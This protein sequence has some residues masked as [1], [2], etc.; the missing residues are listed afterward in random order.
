MKAADILMWGSVNGLK[1]GYLYNWYSA[2]D[3][4]FA[5]TNWSVPT[6][7]EFQTLIDYLIDNGF[8]YDDT[9]V[10]NKIAKSMCDTESWLSSLTVGAVGNIDYPLKR[11]LTNFSLMAAGTRIDN[12]GSLNSWGRLWCS[13]QINS[14]FGY[15]TFAQW[16][17][18]DLT[19][20]G[21]VK[22][23][24]ES[25]RLLYT[26]TGTPTT[27]TDYD[28]NVYDVVFNWYSILDC[29]EL[30]MYPLKRWYFDS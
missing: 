12:F 10:D 27:V 3:A 26:G 11:N 22:Y 24:G 7:S 13:D 15:S 19:L 23:A 20:D 5:P 25:V 17:D 29:S 28:G 30:E 8:N 4:N 21:V 14:V 2:S 6:N 1:Y 16:E 18:I 9:T